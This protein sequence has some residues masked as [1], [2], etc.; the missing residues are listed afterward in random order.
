L[1]ASPPPAV[2]PFLVPL[3]LLL[4]ASCGRQ[5]TPAPVA[6]AGT[7]ASPAVSGSLSTGELVK[8]GRFAEAEVRLRA[9][10]ARADSPAR[11]GQVH[12]QLALSLAGLGRFEEARAEIGR[13]EAVAPGNPEVQRACGNILAASGRHEEAAERYR[14]ALELGA[15]FQARTGLPVPDFQRWRYEFGQALLRAGRAEEGRRELALYEEAQRT[16][17]EVRG[18]EL[19][20]RRRDPA[21][22]RARGEAPRGPLD[23]RTAPAPPASRGSAASAAGGFACADVAS[24]KG[25]SFVHERGAAGRRFLFEAMGGGVAWIDHDGDGDLDVF[26]PQGQPPA[27]DGSFPAVGLDRFF[28]NDGPRGFTDAT[29][30]AGLGGSGYGLGAAVGD[31]DNDGRPDLYVIR[32]GRSALFRNAGGGRFREDPHAVPQAHDSFGGSAGFGDLDGDGWID[33]FATGYVEL[34]LRRHTPCTESLLAGGGPVEIYCGPHAYAGAPDRLYLNH[35]DGTFRD[36]TEGAGL[37]AAGRAA[38]K[39]LGVLLA[40]FDGDRALDV[41]VACDT[42][43]NLLYRN[44]GGGRFEEIG[45]AAGVAASDTGAYEG[46]MGVAA[47]D[48][49]GDGFLDLLV[50][51]YEGE[52]NRLRCGLPGGMFE[53]A[54]A[55][56]GAGLESW[57]YVDL[58]GDQDLFVANGHIFDNA[59]LWSRTSRYRQRNLFLRWDAAPGGGRFVEVGRSLGS[60]FAGERAHR[61]AAAGDHDG[62]GDVDILVAALD[63]PLMLL[64]N[65]TAR[66][67]K[68]Y[69]VVELIGSGPGGRDAVGAMVEVEAGAAKLR[70]WRV[71]GGSYL[72]AGDHRLHFG[73]GAVERI[74]ALRVTWPDGTV[75]PITPPPPPNSRVRIEKGKGVVP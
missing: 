60:A 9:E 22:T 62:D 3:A 58:D 45:L 70:R 2:R 15:A 40:D 49:N 29:A 10:L 71:G 13:A 11:R 36:A 66:E 32:F 20:A 63:E 14:R 37:V 27:A 4:A 75:E 19:E 72:S 48:M 53:D 67:G 59:E 28:R 44:L 26:V 7:A 18:R 69:L 51:N 54:T 35:R 1:R 16:E 50:T 31:V 57:P 17:I 5:P 12:H 74:A 24:E 30:E 46:G 21:G 56:T 55:R 8:A 42:T 34:D 65:R 23:S 43:A 33:L 68:A 64:D 61:G 41:F 25:L 52:F 39:S 47:G 6:P 73:L 38:G